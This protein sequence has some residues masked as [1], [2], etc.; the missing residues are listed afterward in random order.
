MKRYIF[1]VAVWCVGHSLLSQPIIRKADSLLLN[2]EYEAALKLLNANSSTSDPATRYIVENKKAEALTRL[3][4]FDEAEKILNALNGNISPDLQGITKTNLGFLYLNQGR[5][6]RALETLQQAIHDFEKANKGSGLEAAQAMTYLGLVYKSTGKHAQAEEQLLMALSLRQRLL[7]GDHELIAASY[8]DL[9]FAYGEIDND[10]ALDYYEKALTIYQ[11]L[12]GKEHPKIAIASTNI[13]F[14]YRALILY[15]DAV[16]NLETALK[17]WEKVYTRPHPSKA[18]VLLNLGKTY[19]AMG[20]KKAA[21]GYYDKALAMYKSSYGNKH[22]EIAAVLNE[23]GA[24]DLDAEEFG[25]A[26]TTY[27]DA[28]RANVPDFE[29]N[30]LA[31][32]PS[33]EVFYHG[34]VLLYSLLGKAR[35]FEARH[36]QKSLKFSDLDLAL[37]TLQRCDALID[38]L[39]QQS[40][41]ESDKISLG[42]VANE[43]YANGVRMAHE[44]AAVALHK[45]KYRELAFYFAEKSK[46][47]VLLEAISDSDAKSFAGIPAPLLEEEKVLKSAIA[48]T[49]QKLA[50]KPSA[51]EEKYLRETAFSLNRSYEGFV[52]KLETQFPG[53]FN[54]KF[55]AASPSIGQLQQLL[56]D[57]TALLSYFLDETNDNNRLY[58]FQITRKSYKII[59][60]AVPAEFDKYITGLRNGLYFNV[61][62]PYATA[63]RNLFKLLIPTLPRRIKDLVILPTGRLGTLP[64][65]TLLTKKTAVTQSSFAGLPYLIK[66]YQVRYEFSAGLLLQKTKQAGTR[67][68]SIFLCAPIRFPDNDNLNELPA[69][70]SEV[71]E[72]SALFASKKIDNVIYTGKD[73]SEDIV[74]GSG[75]KKYSLLHFAT[76]GIVDENDPQLSRIFLQSASG[77]ED[78][79]LFAG[80]I[81]NLEMDASLVT[82]SACQTGLGKISKGEGVIGLSR[83]LVYAGA[84]NIMVSFWSV[85]DESTSELMKKFYQQMLEKPAAGYSSNLREAKLALLATEKYAAPYYWAPF[86]LIGF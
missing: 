50:Q 85:A 35:V 33:L 61:L 52:K 80:E 6:D 71:K 30:D 49:A 42:V 36:L 37:E 53:Y 66:Q 21:L 65:E 38:K 15:G 7:K 25:R 54:L 10:K 77:A 43:V 9:G 57:Q 78:G 69:T 60:H 51:D 2:S 14:T 76:H 83:A 48:M 4:K 56:D 16:N 40:T 24:L 79:H 39:R 12:H 26:L 75:L 11:K 45:K 20:D 59:D 64:F 22:P 70:E 1:F 34:N 47:A 8:N 84:K 73:A 44:A 72:I 67:A 74:K 23:I 62:G 3:G 46:S 29:S 19:L 82:L 55:N 17:I 86:I 18:F 5:N 32:N 58:I 68:P 27:Q 31:V 28:L 63:A 41:N 13:G 81:Y